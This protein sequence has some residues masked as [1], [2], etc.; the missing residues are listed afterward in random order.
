[1]GKKGI[2]IAM[3][4]LGVVGGAIYGGIKAYQNYQDNSLEA[5]VE[6]ISNINQ[7][8]FGQDMTSVGTVKNDFSQSV[9]LLE[10]K[11]VSEVYVEEGQKVSEGDPLIAYDMTLSELEMEMKE[12]DVATTANKL[13]AAKKQLEK[14]RAM[15]PISRNP[16][17]APTPVAPPQ[18][19]PEPEQPEP[20]PEPQMT[21][22]AYNYITPDSEPSGGAGT[23]EEPY[24]YLCMPGCYVYGAFINGISQEQ[25][26]PVYVSLEIHKKNVL[27][28]KLLGSWKLSGEGGLPM[29]EDDSRWSVATRSQIVEEE[30][31][32]PED[33]EWMDEEPEDV[34]EP[35]EPEGY[36]AEELA[37]MIRDKE[38]NIRDLD[39]ASRKAQLEL[40]QMKQVSDDGIVRAA[41]T[42]IVKDLSEVQ[43][44]S[45]DGSP[46]LTVSGSEGLYVSGA[47]SELQL[48]QVEVGQVIYANSWE[49]GKN[50]EASITEI[51]EYPDTSSEVWGEGNPNVSYYPYTAYIE[52]SEGLS[53]GETVELTMSNQK[54]SQDGI[55][56][57]KAYIRQDDGG[58]YVMKAGG[59]GRLVKQYV[60]TGRILWGDS[61][62]IVEGLTMEDRIAFP[63]GKAAKEGVK[64]K[65]T[66]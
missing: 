59:D 47:L 63:Y 11:N 52:D 48:G 46:F 12:L 5:D 32:D 60:K 14:L 38:E 15:K 23:A 16:A 7:F 56:I 58:K 18:P 17:P 43:E 25:E 24:V 62:E 9:Y 10:D 37:K 66:E 53:N 22:P 36:T 44:I 6:A 33:D 19:T 50:F 13:E 51:S 8:Y 45:N 27:T 42:G 64:V 41:I 29:V 28:G 55:C 26:N 40:E 49:S 35:E 39:L 30:E 65:G 1:M 54:E 20:A 31:E 2:I 3:V 21:G 57:S 4:S 61:T 34:P